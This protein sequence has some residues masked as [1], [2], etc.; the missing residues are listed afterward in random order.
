MSGIGFSANLG[1]NK[2]VGSIGGGVGYSFSG[3]F[4]IGLG[5]S[6]LGFVEKL[7][8]DG[9]SATIISS[10]LIYYPLKQR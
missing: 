1:T 8:G 9:L 7:F 10:S 2:D 4:D 6:R 5:I 3:V